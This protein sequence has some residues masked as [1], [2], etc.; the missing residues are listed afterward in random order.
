MSHVYYVCPV[1]APGIVILLDGP[2][3]V[4]YRP[5]ISDLLDSQDASWSTDIP[6]DPVTGVALKDWCIVAVEASSAVH[7]LLET[8]SEVWPV[9]L[10][11]REK[12]DVRTF[13]SAHGEIS[14]PD[15]DQGILTRLHSITDDG[16]IP[17][18]ANL[19]A[20]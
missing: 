15:D 5:K 14:P 3:D 18:I 9:K 10:G 1:L 8:D 12:Q 7:T 17:Q 4:G 16:H 19:R 6:S 11:G 2:E 13:L 20:G